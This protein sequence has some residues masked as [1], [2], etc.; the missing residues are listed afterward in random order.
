MKL[1]VCGGR[2]YSDHKAMSD[3]MLEYFIF[4]SGENILI[5]GG[6]MGADS[7]AEAIADKHGIRKIIHRPDWE[8]HGK[9]A[10]FIRNQLMIDEKPDM[11]IAF[12]NGN[13]KGTRD[14]IKKAGKA[15]ITTVIIYY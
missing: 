9:G 12:W 2:D 7:F 3:I 14:T 11:V 5:A 10:G 1:L 4:E 6:A 13:S 15:K 8:K